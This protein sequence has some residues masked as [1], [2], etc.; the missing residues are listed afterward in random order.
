MRPAG[1]K[2]ATSLAL[3]ATCFVLLAACGKSSDEPREKGKEPPAA[4][5]PKAPSPPPEVAETEPNDS[6]E[7]AQHL[8]APPVTVRGALGK[9][10]LD[11]Y[12]SEVAEE[13]GHLLHATVDQPGV[14]I[15]VLRGDGT[16]VAAV[17]SPER[18]AAAGLLEG[19]WSVELQQ[20]DGTKE[21]ETPYALELELARWGRGVEWEPNDEAT[22]PGQMRTEKRQPTIPKPAEEGDDKKKDKDTIGVELGHHYVSGWWARQGDVDCFKVPSQQLPLGAVVRFSVAPPKGVRA[23]IEVF[24]DGA[25]VAKAESAKTDDPAVV[26]ALGAGPLRNPVVACVRGVDGMNTEERYRLDVRLFAPESA[27]ELEP[28]DSPER[29]TLIE[30]GKDL[31]GFLTTGDADWYQISGFHEPRVR[32]TVTA[33]EGVEAEAAL[34]QRTSQKPISDIKIEAGKRAELEG[35]T[36]ALLVVRPVGAG[37]TDHLYSVLVEVEEKPSDESP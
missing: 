9:G 12:T 36:P 4:E 16:E 33:P 26:P 32:I 10:D 31:E 8:D 6:R 2:Q 25:S 29:S 17:V 24:S 27:F 34:F 19:P 28:N 30:R 1:Q 20:A 23:G 15:R 3:A 13:G 22:K 11:F 14:R 5:L 7:A 21:A 37:S 35:V 18:V